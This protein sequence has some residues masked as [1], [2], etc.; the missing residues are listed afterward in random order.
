MNKK[1]KATSVGGGDVGDDHQNNVEFEGRK[2]TPYFQRVNVGE[3]S[4][5]GVCSFSL[6]ITGPGT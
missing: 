4:A 3:Q 1:R 2:E 5:A 6:S